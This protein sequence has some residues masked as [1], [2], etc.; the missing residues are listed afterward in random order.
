[1]K[2]LNFGKASSFLPATVLK[3]N[4]TTINFQGF[5]LAFKNVFFQ[6]QLP[7]AASFSL[8][9]CVNC[10]LSEVTYRDGVLKI[11]GIFP[12]KYSCGEVISIKRHVNSI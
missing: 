9:K 2:E 7:L 5:S 4:F 1:M 11:F 10:S 3:T 12:G 8:L 6:E